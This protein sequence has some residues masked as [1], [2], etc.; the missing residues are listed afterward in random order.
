[1]STPDDPTREVLLADAN[2][3]RAWWFFAEDKDIAYPPAEYEAIVEPTTDGGQRVTVTAHTILRDVVLYPDRLDPAAEVDDALVTLLPGES[4]TF[5][6][7][8]GQP[9][10]P[11]RP[12]LRCVNDLMG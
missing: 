8:C 2:G 11:V 6:V 4:H 10:D 9:F 7:H 3:Q 5:V 1:V 12:F